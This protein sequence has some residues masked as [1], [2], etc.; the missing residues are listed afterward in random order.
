[1]AFLTLA[2]SVSWPLLQALTSVGRDALVG[3]HGPYARLL[4]SSATLPCP[5]AA[6]QFALVMLW[7]HPS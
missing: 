2:A 7:L 5:V 3:M 6:M 4:W 1:M